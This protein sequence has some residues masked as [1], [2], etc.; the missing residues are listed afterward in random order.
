MVTVA[1]LFTG[2]PV[3]WFETLD[4]TNRFA[5]N[6]VKKGRTTDGVVY[7]ARYQVKGRGQRGN[8]WESA[9]YRNLTFSIVYEPTFLAA[10]QQ[11]YLSMAVSLSISRFLQTELGLPAKV[12][13][14]NDIY[15]GYDKIAGILIENS[16]RSMNLGYSVIGIGL[17]VNQ[18]A[19]PFELPNPTSIKLHTGVEY[20][21]PEMLDTYLSY[22]E[23]EYLLL[24][25]GRFNE[26]YE[27]YIANLLFYGEER[28]YSADGQVFAATITGVNTD[29]KLILNTRA[30]NRLFAFKEVEF[31]I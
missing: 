1:T 13:W 9:P 15:V 16:L 27:R 5:N 7:A 6:Q 29:G 26:L 19:F 30:G 4:S 2:K 25:A 24:K 3:E 18:E 31:A 8:G 12:K 23:G 22:L 17:N 11:F 21:L 28:H 10:T 14:P 20:S